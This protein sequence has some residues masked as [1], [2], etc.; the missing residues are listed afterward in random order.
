MGDFVRLHMD[1]GTRDIPI[2]KIGITWPPPEYIHITKNSE[3]TGLTE[4]G[5]AKL[6]DKEH[7]FVMRRESFSQITDAD[8]AEMN[9]VAR[10]AEYRYL[11]ESP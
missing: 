6:E 3:I 5:L 9:H 8:I 11:K 4:E 1:V 10:G 7:A 2:A